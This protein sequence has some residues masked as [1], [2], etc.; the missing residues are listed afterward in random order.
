MN[1]ISVSSVNAYFRMDACMRLAIEGE[2]LMDGRRWSDAARF[3]EAAIVHG[4]DD[5]IVLNV[6]YH[7]L[8]VIYHSI[9]TYEKALKYAH[10]QLELAR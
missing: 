6:I 9:G 5:V 4:T 3:Y 8:W 10:Y 1:L 2:K 7:K